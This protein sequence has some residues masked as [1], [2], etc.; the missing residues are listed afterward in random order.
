MAARAGRMFAGLRLL[1]RG[2]AR[3]CTPRPGEHCG[4]LHYRMLARDYPDQPD[5]LARAL[6]ADA[7]IR[8]RAARLSWLREDDPRWA[9]EW[10]AGMGGGHHVRYGR[11]DG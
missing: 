10:V 1:R 6:A 7:W 4:E 8:W 5:R 11:R 9:E 2:Y 3:P